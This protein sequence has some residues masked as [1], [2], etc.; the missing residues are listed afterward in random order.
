M[1]NGDVLHSTKA[2]DEYYGL[3]YGK[4][5]YRLKSGWN[6]EECALNKKIEVV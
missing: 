1:P 5:Y 6:E 2:V 4:T 3:R